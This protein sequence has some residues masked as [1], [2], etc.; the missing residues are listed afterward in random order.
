ML[1]AGNLDV[2]YFG[3]VL[4]YALPTLRKLSAP[5]KEDDMKTTHYKFLSELGEIL[6]A[7]DE[8][9]ASRALAITKGLRF[10]LQ[11]IQVCFV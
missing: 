7:E 10:V 1:R 3:K 2:D 11:Q 8:S 5:A 9:K 6:Q 4:E